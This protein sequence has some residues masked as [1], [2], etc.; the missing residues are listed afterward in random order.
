MKMQLNFDTIVDQS[1]S[2]LTKQ[3]H[4]AQQTLSFPNYKKM[5]LQY[6]YLEHNRYQSTTPR[7]KVESNISSMAFIQ[8]CTT[9]HPYTCIHTPYVPKQY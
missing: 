5:W 4:V 7:M 1:H 2:Q 6:Y 8:Y 3:V 9:A